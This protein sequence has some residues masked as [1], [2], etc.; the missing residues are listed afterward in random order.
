MEEN[1]VN[2][3]NDD[4]FLRLVNESLNIP[5]EGEIRKGK[6]IKIT[7]SEVYVDIGSKSEGIASRWEFKE[8]DIK[9]GDEVFVY[10]EA[11]DGPDGRTIVS[12]HKADFL[13]SWDK[14]K[15]AYQNN[16]TIK[17]KVHKQVKGGLMVDIFGVSAFLPGSQIDVKRV[18]SISSYVGKEIE[19]KVIKINRARKNIVVSRKEVLE[20]DRAKVREKLFELKQGDIVEG[21]VSGIADFGAF[22]QI[23]GIEGIDALIHIS[24]LSWTKIDSPLDVI[25]KG[26]RIKA[27]IL[28]VD[29][30]NL[31]ISLGYKQLQPHPWE[32]VKEKYPIGTKI[33]GNVKKI[34]EYGV[35][36][37]LEPG[38]EGLVHISE[39]KWGKPPAHPSKLV[40]EG[41]T[42]DV[43]ILN[44]DIERQRIS[45][46]MKQAQPDPWSIIE[47]KYP[48]GSIVRGTV[49]EF[50]NFGAYVELEEGIESF[51][52]VGDISW[53]QRFRL[54][55]EALKKG[56]K[57]RAK[58]L[59]IDKKDRFIE[60]GIK[61]LYD[62]PWNEI[63]KQL[64]PGTTLKATVKEVGQR[65]IL[66]EIDKGLEG[67]IPGSQLQKRGDLKESYTP[68]EELNLR[69][70]KVEPHRKRVLLS[71]KEYYKMQEKAEIDN[72]KSAPARVNLG[73]VLQAELQ[74]LEELKKGLEEKTD[75]EEQDTAPEEETQNE[76]VEI[77]E[78]KNPEQEETQEET[79]DKG[80]EES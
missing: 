36:V 19:V 61:Q 9:E 10:I 55:E 76:N 62:N 13:M 27:K 78:E 50:G 40:K 32:K 53:T 2:A 57:I 68:G 23:D 48:I 38:I 15:E 17:G 56:Q 51:L 16:T 66:V 37:E 35:F 77:E 52:H 75:G 65:G 12:K 21:V 22:V 30:M 63:L 33:K 29:P 24:D 69:V 20:E 58:V 26:D 5:N 42:I 8:P 18:K 11:L 67:F 39:M 79:E 73:E 71:E 34:I 80:S 72:Y 1:I 7:P 54:P 44:V 4:E 43:V 49:K 31:K 6:I 59:N 41:D 74:K 70:L 46:G 60:L 25:E 28:E 45:L 3:T 64:P 47:E 14:I